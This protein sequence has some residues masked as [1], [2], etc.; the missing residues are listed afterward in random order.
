MLAL[1]LIPL[2][3]LALMAIL[4]AI[5]PASKHR[6]M[7]DSAITD[8]MKNELI[9]QWA[10]NKALTKIQEASLRSGA[11]SP[12]F[13]WGYAYQYKDYNPPCQLALKLSDS[14]RYTMTANNQ[15]IVSEAVKALMRDY[16]KSE[17][18]AKRQERE[19]LK[20][21]KSYGLATA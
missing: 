9:N 20:V 4:D 14:E 2:Y 3:L 17:R 13:G 5:R 8:D 1:I 15:A 21:L 19:H 11:I 7:A 18:T 6:F 10:A 16:R 12:L